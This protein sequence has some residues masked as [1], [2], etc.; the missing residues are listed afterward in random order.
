LLNWQSSKRPPQRS[1]AAIFAGVAIFVGLYDLWAVRS[2]GYRFVWNQDL[3]GYYDYLGRAFAAGHLY[4]PIQPAPEVLALSN[5]Y[6]PTAAVDFKMHDM[7]YRNGHYYLYH[8]PAPALLLFAPFRLLTRHDLPENF[9]LFLL[10]YGGFLFSAAALLRLLELAAVRPPPAFLA[11]VL[12]ALAVCQCVPYLMS[13]VWVY[14][15]AIGSA[16]FFSSA[17]IF[18]LFRGWW[19]ASGLMFGLAVASR[20]HMLFAA[21]IAVAAIAA[22]RKLRVHLPVFA[23]TLA[24]VGIAIAAYN[25]ARFSDP[26]EFGVHY[27]FAGANQNSIHLAA[28][29][30][31]PGLY[32]FLFAAPEFGPVF[33]WVHLVTRPITLPPG[34]FIEPI[35]GALWLAPIV[36]A[37]FTIP[38]CSIRP[39]L[40]MLS[41]SSASILL[42]LA[43]TGFTT[44]RYEVDFLPMLVLA[45][46]AVCVIRGWRAALAPVIFYSVIVNLALGI[47]GPY[48]E[49]RRNR[50]QTFVR[51]ARWFS[52]LSDY[53]PALN[54]HIA[55]DLAGPQITIGDR[56]LHYELSARD[57]RLI[58][59]SDT[60]TVVGDLPADT[61]PRLHFDYTAPRVTIS[62]DGRPI[63]THDVGP[64]V[65]APSQIRVSIAGEQP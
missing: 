43:A 21:A 37:A 2:A 54:P 35:A 16:Y 42:F 44:Q 47:T 26:F 58:S 62:F 11:I 51:I 31:V 27:L 20:P 7:A 39:W 18:F 56:T 65:T 28:A 22:Q 60:S 64:L 40:W 53:R 63:L 25:Y 30:L 41:A 55:R 8:G 33:P 50:P 17:A 45:A 32:H 48:D 6:D 61:T 10:C 29:N 19:A 14:E 57:H 1:S 36:L 3:P 24:F 13:R 49:M 46:L 52:P 4:L 34:Y 23:G 5:P 59:K 12:L 9:A 15:I 38:R